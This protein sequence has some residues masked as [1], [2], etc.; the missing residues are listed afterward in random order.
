MYINY[1]S[2]M[3][4][5]SGLKTDILLLFHDKSQGRRE[6]RSRDEGPTE[7]ILYTLTFLFFN[8]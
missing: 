2:G 8:I 3:L 4:C 7:K 5:V 1:T 6:G